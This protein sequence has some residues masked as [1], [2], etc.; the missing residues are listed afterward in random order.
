MVAAINLISASDDR[1]VPWSFFGNRKGDRQ[2]MLEAFEDVPNGIARLGNSGFMK[3]LIVTDEQVARV[4]LA[5]HFVLCPFG[6]L[7]PDTWRILETL[8]AGAIP[9][10]V[11]LGR[12]DYFR[13]V[14]GDHPFIVEETWEE[15]AQKV[16]HLLANPAELARSHEAASIWYSKFERNLAEDVS[17]ILQGDY[18]HLVSP[19][20]RFQ[21][22][23]RWN[24]KIRFVFWSY[25]HWPVFKKRFFTLLDEL[26]TL[27]RRRAK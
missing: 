2:E 13:F 24:M 5:S 23:A 21:A 17:S 16:K 26:R 25:F 12:I 7:S 11:R 4:M 20:F 27:R 14:F 10:S 9:V 8:E 18:K 6:S 19:Q 1:T 15:A 22:A 3:N